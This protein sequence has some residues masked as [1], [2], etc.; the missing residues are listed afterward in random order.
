[1]A[2]KIQTQK[3]NEIIAYLYIL[4]GFLIYM[5]I[6]SIYSWSLFRK[7]LEETLNIKATQSGLPYMTFLLIFSF[8]MPFAGNLI[9]KLKPFR[10]ILLGN[11]FLL[12]G[13]L[14]ASLSRKIF[15][16][17]ISYGILVG[18]GVGIIYGVPI[19]VIS[20]WLPKKRG[21]AMGLTLAG[22]GAS[23][24]AT[25][26]LI[27]H[28]IS[29]YGPF[30]TFKILGIL[31]FFIIL[32]FSLPLK[33]P[34]HSEKTINQ[35]NNKD[36]IDIDTKMMLKTK[37]FYSLWT[38]FMFGTLIGLTI[39]GITSPFAQE[40]VGI[41]SKTAALLVSLFAVFN[42]IGRPLFGFLT[43]KLKPFKTILLSYIIII[44]SSILGLLLNSGK[45]TLFAVVFSLLWLTLGGWL[46]IAPSATSIIFGAKYYVQ[47]YGFVYTAYGVGA[48]LG[49]FL[50]GKIRDNLGSYIYI[51][52][53]LIFISILG[54]I[55]SATFLK[56]SNYITKTLN[57]QKNL[58]S[59]KYRKD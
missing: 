32:I 28:F 50:S 14:L 57:P 2:S 55:I 36:N 39:I 33:F 54:T 8:T 27:R 23:P 40:I 13:F 48:I 35:D 41:D 30:L 22:F 7:P 9:E 53:P 34:D 19:G 18:L 16:I 26:P 56:E 11:I 1:M 49:V 59:W 20:K 46:A 6:G 47:N 12:F 5:C 58:L 52:Y 43:D 45:I 37:E 44:I 15:H 10:T 4:F 29:V 21:L 17:T 3:S 24:F 42:G 25:A 38:C 51:F 31:F